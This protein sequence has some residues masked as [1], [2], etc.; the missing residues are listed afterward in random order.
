MFREERP[1]I[2][3]LGPFCGE[4]VVQLAARGARLQV[5]RFDPPEPTPAPE[6]G[7]APPK[8]VPIVIGQPADR[9]DLVLAWEQI[10]FVP[11][12]RLKDFGAE[13]R[14]VTRVGGWILFL[15][16]ARTGSERDVRVR[17]RLLGDGSL[18]RE[19]VEETPRSR[20]VHPNREIERAMKGLSLQGIHLQRNQM[21]EFLWVRKE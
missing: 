6:P 20:W 2:L 4:T 13:L 16:S 11:P 1:E 17:Y 9:F 14:R 7:E 18:V 12:E 19:P 3:D 5:D 8:P 21:R 10:D 15:S